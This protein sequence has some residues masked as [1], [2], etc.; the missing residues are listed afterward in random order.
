MVVTR[1]NLLNKGAA[2]CAAGVSVAAGRRDFSFLGS[3][4]AAPS[5]AELMDPGP[6]PDKFL[7]VPDAPV[8][9]IEYASLTCTH[10][11]MFAISTFPLVKAKLIQTGKIR[12]TIREFALDE[13]AAAAAMLARASG[14][15]YFE[16]VETLL[17]QQSDWISDRIQPLMSLAV[18][19]FGFTPA[20]FKACLADRQLLDNVYKAFKRAGTLGVSSAPSF[21]VN[22]ELQSG[23]RTFAEVESMVARNLKV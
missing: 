4:V 14:D 21:F 10:C 13:F 2:V 1:R 3:A 23:F 5:I 15:R 6:F 7:G 18:S 19:R 11:A 20:T 12:Y 8:T 22:G 16:V 9:I 17:Q